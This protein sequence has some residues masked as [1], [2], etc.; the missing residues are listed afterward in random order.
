VVISVGRRGDLSRQ[1]SADCRY[2]LRETAVAGDSDAT[3]L[4]QLGELCLDG[5]EVRELAGVVVG[6]GVLDDTVFVDDEGGTFGDAAHGEIQLRGELLVGDAVGLGDFVIVVA[7]E[8]DLDAFFLGPGFLR[9]G[10]VA[11]DADD[12]G[13]G[14]VGEAFRD[15]AEFVGADAGVDHR[16]EQ[17]DDVFA[18]VVGE[19]DQVEAVGGFGREGEVGGGGSGGKH[20]V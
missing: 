16:E 7:G 3:D 6:F 11:A 5:F 8:G 10:I 14:E 13:A 17:E 1:A 9:E 18:F 2:K 19:F 4:V 12:L 15:G 20:G